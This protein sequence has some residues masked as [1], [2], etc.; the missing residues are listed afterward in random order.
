M[1]FYLDGGGG[2]WGEFLL[3]IVPNS[4]LVLG[5][6]GSVCGW[7]L[8]Y[9]ASPCQSQTDWPQVHRINQP[10]PHTL[11]ERSP[12]LHHGVPGHVL[13]SA[14]LT[15]NRHQHHNHATL[16]QSV[17]A[18]YGMQ[19]GHCYTGLSNCVQ[20]HLGLHPMVTPFGNWKRTERFQTNC[21]FTIVKLTWP[22]TI[23][24]WLVHH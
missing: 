12:I 20:L 9:A 22:K 5:V 4:N 13:S 15:G 6:G 16:W 7:W 3:G 10:S 21:S 1:Y 19:H 23:S 24:K 17:A 14:N 2:F 11:R 8:V 18:T